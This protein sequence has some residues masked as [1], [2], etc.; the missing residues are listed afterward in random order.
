VKD[1]GL[2]VS[3]IKVVIIAPTPALRAGLKDLLRKD[4]IIQTVYEGSFLPDLTD[5]PAEVDV[6]ILANPDRDIHLLNL[7]SDHNGQDVALLP[8]CLLLGD[9]IEDWRRLVESPVRAWGW[10]TLDLSADEL[11]AAVRAL[12]EGLLVA[13]GHLV[14][15]LIDNLQ[16]GYY[17]AVNNEDNQA[18]VS[19]TGREHE[20]FELLAQGLA[21][22]QIAQ[23][24]GISENTVKFHISSIYTKLG[25][26]NRTEAVRIGLRKGLLTL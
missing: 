1:S 10:M 22:K 24:L 3:I 2:Q 18:F 6:M 23:Q 8:A 4:E 25:A 5:I 13:D 14:R 12:F 17:E 9:I 21:N 15:R 20:T 26:T 11:I 19:L 16:A 7:Q